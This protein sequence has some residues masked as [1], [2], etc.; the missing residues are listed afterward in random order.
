MSC[1]GVLVCGLAAVKMRPA[2]Q[3]AT[4]PDELL[5]KAYP[6][7]LAHW[8]RN[9]QELLRAISVVRSTA[10]GWVVDLKPQERK[11]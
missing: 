2:K 5:A 4:V 10:R 9:R 6:D 3:Q 8:E 11:Q 1:D 7:H